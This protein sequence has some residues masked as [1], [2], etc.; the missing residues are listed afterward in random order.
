MLPQVHIRF[1]PGNQR[2]SPLAHTG[3][4]KRRCRLFPTPAR[5]R[6]EPLPKSQSEQTTIRANRRKNP[7]TAVPVQYCCYR[8]DPLPPK[9]SAF[10]RLSFPPRASLFRFVRW[11]CSRAHK[12]HDPTAS[13]DAPSD[14][15]S[16]RPHKSCPKNPYQSDEKPDAPAHPLPTIVRPSLQGNSKWHWE[17]PPERAKSRWVSR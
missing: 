1:E 3:T 12:R 16:A 11:Q 10:L 17:L 14:C 8:S 15:A 7:P 6:P 2:D 13:T 5:C 4:A 9:A